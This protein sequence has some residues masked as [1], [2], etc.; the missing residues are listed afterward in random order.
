[1]ETKTALGLCFMII[2]S[3]FTFICAAN[4][5]AVTP[6]VGGESE[7]FLKHFDKNN[8]GKVSREEFPGPDKAFYHLDKN[9]DGFIDA[10]EAPK[11][12][13]PGKRKSRY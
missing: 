9:R 11:G 7:D 1:M 12:P 8:D 13:P 3:G 2:F 6:R 5:F 10:R 4:I